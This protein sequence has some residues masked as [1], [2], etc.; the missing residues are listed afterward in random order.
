[1][2]GI[3]DYS[4]TA[5]N[6]TMYVPEGCAPSSVNDGI[7]QVQADIRTWYNGGEWQDLGNTPTYVSTSSFSLTGDQT[8]FY[9]VGR[10]VKIT[11]SST[12]YGTISASA[13]TSLTTVTVTLDSG[14]ISA[15][16]SAVAVGI[17]SAPSGGTGSSL[18]SSGLV[19]TSGAQTLT[20][21]TLTSPKINEILD[22]NGNELLKFTTT[23]SA[24]NELTLTNAATGAGATLSATGG[25]TNIDVNIQAK[26]TGAVN[27]KGTADTAAEVRLFE[28][29]D[30]G[31]NYVGLKA[32]TALASSLTFTLP[33]ADGTSGQA[34]TTNGSGG[35]SFATG[36]KYIQTVSSLSGAVATGSTVIPDDDTI[37]QN[38]EGDEYFTVTITPTNSSN[39]LVIDATVNIASTVGNQLIIALFQDSTANALAVGVN[40]WQ[41]T[42]KLQQVSLKYTMTAGTTSATTFKIRAG[43]SA[44]GTTTINGEGGSRKFGGALVSGIIISEVTA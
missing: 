21:K 4:T 8:A 14:S 11:D 12:L 7:R 20:N 40:R 18:S 3:K 35:L 19:N 15:S 27:L 31:S 13:Y 39:K 23:T 1:M 28:D 2:T 36:S 41:T 22:S 25:D 38:T 42:G 17:I 34:L 43:A 44:A 6:N 9:P 37:P 26:G 16:I 30:N 33:S 32:A 29:T 10:R 24:V 5:S